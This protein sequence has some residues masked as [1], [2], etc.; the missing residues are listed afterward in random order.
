MQSNEFCHAKQQVN[1]VRDS[2]IND[3]S[4]VAYHSLHDL[5]GAWYDV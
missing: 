5:H 3:I 2:I 4:K 1:N